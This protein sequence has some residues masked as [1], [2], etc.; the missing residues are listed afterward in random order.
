MPLR[1]SEGRRLLATGDARVTRV[2]ACALTGALVE[3]CALASAVLE[4]ATVDACADE[5][6]DLGAV[7]S[8]FDRTGVSVLTSR[9][10]VVKAGIAVVKSRAVGEPEVTEVDSEAS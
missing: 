2:E 5:P 8:T 4:A 7:V 10:S 1:R 3:A 9:V 6:A